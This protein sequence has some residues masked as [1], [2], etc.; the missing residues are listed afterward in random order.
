MVP[1]FGF[2][3]FVRLADCQRALSPRGRTITRPAYAQDRNI[4]FSFDG[5]DVTVFLSAD[6]LDQLT[7]RAPRTRL[8]PGPI[9]LNN[10]GPRVWSLERDRPSETQAS[11]YRAFTP[12]GL[13]GQ[14]E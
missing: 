1:R 5:A 11:P 13:L 8:G 12:F 10:R 2:C 6:G 14:R 7:I 9:S 4:S 3:Q